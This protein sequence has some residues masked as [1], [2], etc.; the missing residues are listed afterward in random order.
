MLVTLTTETI[1]LTSKLLKQGYQYHKIRRAFSKFYNGHS[2]L[3][4][5]YDNCFK[6]FL[7]QGILE[8]ILYGD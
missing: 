8:P 1:F 3:I 2:E 7:Q 5:K 6:T 4:V